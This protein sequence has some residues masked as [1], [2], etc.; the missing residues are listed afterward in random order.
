MWCR[1]KFNDVCSKIKEQGEFHGYPIYSKEE[2]YEKIADEI[3][4]PKERIKKWT[5][6]GSKGPRNPEDLKAIEELFGISFWNYSDYQ[7]P[8]N[9]C[10]D[11]SKKSTQKCYQIIKKYLQSWDLENESRLVKMVG[12]I[13]KLRVSIPPDIY[14]K[15]Q[16]F[17]TEEIDALTYDYE[18]I[19]SA[20]YNEEY[21]FFDEDH[22]FHIKGEKEFNQMLGEYLKVVH[23]VET[24]LDE[25][26]MKELSPVILET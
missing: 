19:F 7:S 14:K 20:M 16:K 25:F 2:L 1:D 15:I 9:S 11:F 8:Y 21:G 3:H 4:I 18:N 6:Q 5:Q 17:I 22:V 23:N 26:A 24:R 10:S 13:D 12:K